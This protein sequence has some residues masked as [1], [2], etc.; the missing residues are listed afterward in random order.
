MSKDVQQCRGVLADSTIAAVWR[1]RYAR[2][3]FEHVVFSKQHAAAGRAVKSH[4]SGGP[5]A[6][7]S[8]YINATQ[9]R[10]LTFRQQLLVAGIFRRHHPSLARRA[11][12]F[13]VRH[14]RA[15]T[16]RRIRYITSPLPSSRAGRSPDS[17]P[18]PPRLTRCPCSHSVVARVREPP[19]K[20]K[21]SKADV[22]LVR[23][24]RAGAR[25][26]ERQSARLP[27]AYL[28]L[29]GLRG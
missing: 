7:D 18:A 17:I 27:G 12:S 26:L 14:S 10:D 29:V 28:P 9:P 1:I 8:T 22:A 4:L 11:T 16:S 19:A 5:P 2:D 13:A 24:H 23:F 6:I 21:H 15:Y 3:D 20:A 25:C